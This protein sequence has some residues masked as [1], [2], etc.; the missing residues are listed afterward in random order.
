MNLNEYIDKAFENARTKG[1]HDGFNKL[2]ESISLHTG[3]LDKDKT[4]LLKYVVRTEM[5]KDLGLLTSEIGEAV[6]FARTQPKIMEINNKDTWKDTIEEEVADIFI[7][8][9]DFCGKHD[10]DLEYYV[11][12]KMEYNST[13]ERLHGKEL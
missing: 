3:L 9:C 5:I 1:F 8:L 7:R 13:R 10:I 2:V 12:K 11:N 6:E 4:K